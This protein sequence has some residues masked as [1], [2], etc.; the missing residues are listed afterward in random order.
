MLWSRS[1]LPI[2][3]IWPS[4]TSRNW[5]GPLRNI[6]RN[7]SSDFQIGRIFQL[8]YNFISVPPAEPPSISGILTSYLPGDFVNLN[9]STFNVSMVFIWIVLLLEWIVHCIVFFIE[10]FESI[11]TAPL[12]RI[13]IFS[14]TVKF[15]S[16]VKMDSQSRGSQWIWNGETL[17][18]TFT[19][20]FRWGNIVIL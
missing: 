14:F 2:S 11:F 13:V 15:E 6:S 16:S 19:T 1:L 20:I 8:K 17:S 10:M 12:Y 7:I 9:C 3:N 18:T 5:V 4:E